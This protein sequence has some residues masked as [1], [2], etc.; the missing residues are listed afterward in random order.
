VQWDFYRLDPDKNWEIDL[1]D[2]ESKIDASV[3]AILVNNPSNPCGSCW[4]REHMEAILAL[5]DK[6]GVPLICDEVY[7][8][9]TY[10]EERPFISFGN[11]TTK[12]PLICVGSISKILCVPGWRLGWSIVYNHQGYFDKVINN[13]GLQSMILLHP[14]SLVQAAL[15]RILAEVPESHFTGMKEKLKATS[16]VAFERFSKI[17]GMIPVKSSAA[18]YMM[19]CI[20]MNHFEGIE[21]DVDF[22]K[23]FL[24]EQNAFC[25]PSKC[26]NAK[27]MFRVVLCVKVETINT[28]ADRLEAFCASHAKK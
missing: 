22:V 10:D 14:C 12:T 16:E 7:H 3:K 5:S 6:H 23:K 1:A 20:D 26:F 9:L 11:L 19:V 21:D 25:F 18:M 24:A 17:P 13:L 15:P 28:F 8:G 2:L 4:T 27:N